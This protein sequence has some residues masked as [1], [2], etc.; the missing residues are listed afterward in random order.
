MKW[1]LLD[2]CGVLSTSALPSIVGGL[3]SSMILVGYNYSGYN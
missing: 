2:T 1:G 3:C